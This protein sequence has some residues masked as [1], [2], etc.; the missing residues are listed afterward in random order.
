MVSQP[1]YWNYFLTDERGRC[2]V[3]RN[4][5]VDL[6]A[7]R[8]PLPQ[9]P[10]GWQ[11]ISVLYERD[12]L[13]MGLTRKF[14]LSYSYVMNA[15]T[16]LRKIFY[17][18][19]VE[20]KVYLVIQ[21]LT[22]EL[23]DTTFLWRYKFFYKGE[24]ELSKLQDEELKVTVPTIEGGVQRLFDANKDTVYEIPFDSD[25]I[26]VKMDGL[27]LYE[28]YNYLIPSQITNPLKQQHLI[29]AGF[30]T[31]DGQAPGMAAFSVFYT[32]LVAN[33]PGENDFP[34]RTDYLF[35]TTQAIAGVRLT[36]TIRVRTTFAAAFED[37]N[38]RAQLITS[39]GRTI[40]LLS[41]HISGAFTDFP[42]DVTI[43]TQV[44]ETFFLVGTLFGFGPI[45]AIEYAETR[46]AINLH[47]RYQTTYCKAFKAIDLFKKLAAK[48]GID[49]NVC[50]SELLTS[51][52]FIVIT[53][54][55]AIRGL[56]GSAIKTSMGEFL[57]FCRTEHAGGFGI[58]KGFLVVEDF[59]HF[60]N[61]SVVKPL[62]NA[63]EVKVSYA[64]DLFAKSIKVGY[65]PQDIDEVNG[66]FS[67]NNTFV[68]STP[69][70][71][72][73]KELNLVC[74]YLAD[75]YLIETRR[76]NL[77]GKTTT[78]NQ[79]DNDTFLLN[80]DIGNPISLHADAFHASNTT[81][82]FTNATEFYQSAKV[83]DR[84]TL[85]NTFANDKTFTITS[86]VR[87]ALLNEVWVQT[88]ESITPETGATNI[89]IQIPLY[90]LKRVTYTEL[91]GIPVDG[92]VFNIEYLTPK[93]ML[94]RYIL[95]INSIMDGF[96]GQF[97]KYLSTDK[98]ADLKFRRTT[99]ISDITIEEK[100]DVVIGTEKLFLPRLFDFENEVP[101]D[102]VDW[103][104]ENP[105][106][107]FSMDYLNYRFVL[108]SKNMGIAP[109]TLKEQSFKMLCAPNNNL[110]TLE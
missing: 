35:I 56:P 108:F 6:T 70:T 13:H 109:N 27:F 52:S 61:T 103:M 105:N 110:L 3:I 69:N 72:T 29:G 79:N 22:Q 98:N 10:D 71:H 53:C 91:S 55:N 101:V 85:V 68:F 77:E 74:P 104:D 47:S 66:K 60:L 82:V 100:A 67:F 94:N 8:I 64:E 54:G 7:E 31:Q 96:A 19:N 89:T 40:D 11:D 9:T 28:T 57:E 12:F 42:F 62:G 83:G 84:F 30:T 38:Y 39:K 14:G 51:V 87:I 2:Y 48:M 97:L 21:E 41:G 95:Y 65:Q 26:T 17:E 16:V 50:T 24:I 81:M 33:N 88:A 49:P 76:Q 23:T 90:R 46:F 107:A 102:L 63:K 106:T 32:D 44:N 58:E 45:D 43:D 15:A 4:G 92:D 34:N 37:T 78:D 1:P 80:V 25:A 99:Q 75:P 86:I 59:L 73:D 93:Q 5:R 36:G 18:Q 20:A